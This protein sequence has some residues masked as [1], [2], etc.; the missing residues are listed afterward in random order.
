[1]NAT[2]TTKLA[3]VG[4]IPLLLLATGCIATRKFVRNNQAPLETRVASLDQKVDQ[5]TSQNAQDIK[6]LDKKTEAGIAQA[7][8]GADQANQAA[9]EADQHAQS[10]NETAANGLSAA[11]HAQ[12]MI[13][14]IY[15]YQAAHHTTITFGLNKSDLTKGN[16]QSLDEVAEAVGPLKHYV[17]Q[18]QGYTDVTG[19]KQHNLALSQR[20]ADAVV[21]Y[22]TLSH[23]VPLVQIHS[24]G[25][26]EEAPAAANNTRKGRAANR[27]VEITVLVPQF[28]T[29]AAQTNQTSSGGVN[30]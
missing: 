10:A 1:M 18:I 3:A 4:I 30:H 13:D 8:S 15:N 6:E 24:L 19:P 26:G 29:E 27:R 21:R 12:K 25:Y 7:Q 22:L 16:K 17:I 2:K 5:K 23:N 14:N 9:K 28:E 11:N 20:R